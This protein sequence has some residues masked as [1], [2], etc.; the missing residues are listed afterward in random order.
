M[1][2]PGRSAQQG[3]TLV[4][5]VMTIVIIGIAAAALFSAMAAITGHSADPMLRQQSLAIAEA[6][7]E[8]ITLQAF[9]TSTSCA[10]SNNG[11]GRGNFDDVCDYNGLFYGGA[12]SLAPRNAV[13]STPLVG[14]TAYQVAVQVSAQALNGIAS[15][16]ALRIT[17]NVTDPAGQALTLTGYRTR[18]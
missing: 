16:N 6:Y 14:L 12:Q 7:M 18:Y 15:A 5:L 2:P 8:E 13:S 9:P 1:K 11:A 3:M 10:A 17:V 4:E